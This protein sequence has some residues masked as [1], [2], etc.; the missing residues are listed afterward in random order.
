MRKPVYAMLIAAAIAGLSF[1]ALAHHSHAMFDHTV[2]KTITGT[3]ANFSFRNP[4]V[5]LYIDVK[6]ENGQVVSWAVEMSNIQNTLRSGIRQSTFKT[7]DVVTVTL[8]PLRDGR[9]GGNFTVIAA[10]DGKL[11]R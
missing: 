6:G 8:N 11:Y 3:V 10:A 9:P 7:G 5:F 2:E 1:P 4:H